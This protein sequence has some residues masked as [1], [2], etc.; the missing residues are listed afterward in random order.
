[1]ILAVGPTTPASLVCGDNTSRRRRRRRHSDDDDDNDESEVSD[2]D[3][4]DD[5][6]DDTASEMHDTQDIEEEE[7]DDDNENDDEISPETPQ[8]QPPS[9]GE[10]GSAFADD[11]TASMFSEAV[12][13]DDNASAALTSERADA[14]ATAAFTLPPASERSWAPQIRHESCI[15]TACWL[16]VPWRLSVNADRLAT[17]VAPSWEAPTQIITSGDDHMVKFWDVRQ[18]MG[19]TSPKPNGWDVFGPFSSSTAPQPPC[20]G[21]TNLVTRTSV[22]A[23]G[24]PPGAVVPLA[25][26][27]SGHL[28]NVFHVTPVPSSP[29]LVLTCGADGQL[30]KCHVERPQSS[31]LV[32]RPQQ[33]RTRGGGGENDDNS[34]LDDYLMMTALGMAY[35]HQLLTEHT[36]L[37]CSD[38]GL[39]R[40]D[41]RVGPRDQ[42]RHAFK[43]IAK[44]QS[45]QSYSYLSGIK[46]CA[47]WSPSLGTNEAKEGHLVDSNYVFAGGSGDE[48]HLFD[49][50]MDAGGDENSRVVERYRPRILRNGD[51][52]SVCGLDVSK[53]GRELL[54]SYESDQIYTF[55]I[56][57]QA[58]SS[59]GPT[60][61]EI[62]EW[63]DLY[64]QDSDEFVSDLASYG[65]H[66][67]RFTFLKSARYAGPN[68][69]YICTGSDSG[70]AWIYNKSN[71]TVASLLS[72]D[73]HVCNGVVPHPSLPVFI[74]Y[75]IDS[76]AKVWRASRPI[77]THKSDSNKCRAIVARSRPYQMC[78]MVKNPV[79]VQQRCA[80]FDDASTPMNIYPDYIPT[81]QE[82][83][84]AGRFMPNML[85][86][87][88]GG[89]DGAPRIGNAFRTL[90]YLLRSNRYECCRAS[91]AER[92]GP[93]E[94]PLNSLAHRLSRMRLQH[95][96]DQLGL[97]IDNGDHPYLWRAASE[98]ANHYLHP[99]DMVPDFPSDWIQWDP[100]MHQNPQALCRNFTLQ[101]YPTE[102]L[103]QEAQ[104]ESLMAKKSIGQDARQLT[105]YPWLQHMV[106]EETDNEF[107]WPPGDDQAMEEANSE[108]KTDEPE[109]P[110]SLES[111]EYSRKVLYYTALLCKEGGN[112]AMKE[113]NLEEAARRYDKAVQYCA[114][115]FVACKG[116]GAHIPHL[117]DGMSTR[118][119]LQQESSGQSSSSP[120]TKKAYVYTWCPLFRIWISCHLNL[121]LLFTKPGLCKFQG[122]ACNQAQIALRLLE[123]YT[124]EAGKVCYSDN[125]LR[126]KEPVETYQEARRL[127][128]KA[129]FRLGCAEME[130]GNY[131]DACKSLE[132]SIAAASTTDNGKVDPAVHRRLQVAR[133]RTSSQ[134]KRNRRRFEAALAGGSSG[135][136]GKANC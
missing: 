30:R 133:S 21:S 80:I 136:N 65:G 55:P 112:A 106:E 113:G 102:E 108:A 73:S 66:L 1:M 20:C 79:L 129:Y 77:E 83:I 81:S 68:D 26:I 13:E 100:A 25:S 109:L 84:C 125:Y 40:F 23:H 101:E 58:A 91:K 6:S 12:G 69:D 103:R 56:F 43:L 97:I 10:A 45:W 131:L 114:V 46:A 72:A 39:F 105:R 22:P 119:A 62:D 134:K 44:K 59:A 60:L 35:S 15:N 75:G 89:Y 42:S 17:T 86:A 132:D 34:D 88:A 7:D 33:Q 124:K 48:V 31:G 127:Q 38:R 53:D 70:H 50:R 90:P 8:L 24:M 9:S 32:M 122:E 128:A 16:D 120:T 29:G 67:N 78:P 96:A 3:D 51:N 104:T 116:G 47:V 110:F 76:T 41:M 126:D 4:D 118:V 61:E 93:I 99:A 5:D 74:T 37:L 28:G 121:A 52:V 64:L 87:V 49:L 98:S 85:W 135:G 94:G 2:D 82:V 11:D 107:W 63:S 19:S 111:I 123:P 36:G 95:Q 115:A 117:T 18:A 14:T 71:G 27:S 92:D 57:N 130:M 54:V